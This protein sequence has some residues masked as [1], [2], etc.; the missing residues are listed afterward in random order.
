MVV[1]ICRWAFGFRVV[2]VVV[3]CVGCFVE[4]F[5]CFLKKFGVVNY[6]RDGRFLF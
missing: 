3:V 5:Y 2:I 6:K 1:F 4:F